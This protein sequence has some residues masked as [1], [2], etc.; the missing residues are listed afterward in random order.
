VVTAAELNLEDVH[1][2][3]ATGIPDLKV[4]LDVHS[5]IDQMLAGAAFLYGS[6]RLVRAPSAAMAMR[7]FAFS[8]TYVTLLFGALTVDVIV[9]HGL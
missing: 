3:L 7:L 2:D 6:V 1:G 5:L 9:R 4:G 8:I